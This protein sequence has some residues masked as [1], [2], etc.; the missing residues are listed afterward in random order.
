MGLAN[1]CVECLWFSYKNIIRYFTLCTL[2][3]FLLACAEDKEEQAF[4]ANLIE[5]ALNDENRKIGDAFLLENKQRE[6]VITTASGLQYEVIK[7]GVGKRPE[8]IDIV[9]VHYK[10]SLVDGQVFDSSYDRGQSSQFPLNRVV[11]GWREAL[12]KMKVGGHWR[13]Y[14]P[15]QLAYGAKSPTELIAANSALIF[16]IELLDILKEERDELDDK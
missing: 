3:F 7:E 5:K 6:G 12:L 11:K 1:Q 16:E 8:I 9:Q 2:C 4:R 13:I 10:G 15:A 14:L